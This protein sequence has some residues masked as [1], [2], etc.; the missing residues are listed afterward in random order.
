MQHD[1]LPLLA[2][3][4]V[5]LALGLGLMRRG[6][7]SG[8]RGPYVRQKG[9]ALLYAGVICLAAGLALDVCAGAAW[10]LS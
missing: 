7:L 1:A 8:H 9:S 3:G 10:L 4:A 6:Y 2:I 5:T